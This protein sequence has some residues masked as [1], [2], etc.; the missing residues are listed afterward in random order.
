MKE[1]VKDEKKQRIGLID[2]ELLRSKIY[3]VRGQKVM[4]L[5]FKCQRKSWKKS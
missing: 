1:I 3:E 2:E 4:T 5:C